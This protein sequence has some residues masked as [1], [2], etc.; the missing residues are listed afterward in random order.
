M[1]SYLMGLESQILV[2]AFTY[3]NTLLGMSGIIGIGL[4]QASMSKIQGLLKAAP[5]FFND[6]NLM[7]NTDGSVKIRLQKCYTE[8]MDWRH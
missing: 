4:I 3:F 8:I 5:T 1:Q 7:K 2:L 6:L